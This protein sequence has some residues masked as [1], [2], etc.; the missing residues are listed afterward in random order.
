[1]TSFWASQCNARGQIWVSPWVM[2]R[3]RKLWEQPTAYMPERFAGKP[4]PW[5]ANAAYLP[6][7]S[8]PRTCIGATFA[9]CE[10]QIMLAT[11]L[12]RYRISSDDPRPVL[13]VARVTIEPSFAPMF[14]LEKIVETR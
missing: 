13:P 9:M 6:F 14:Q 10:A 3:H 1:M 7:G 11:L 8:G 5:T 2:H 4:S 12:N